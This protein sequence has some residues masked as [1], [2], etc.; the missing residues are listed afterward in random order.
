M[1]DLHAM[2]LAIRDGAAR[3]TIL[4]ARVVKQD[5]KIDTLQCLHE[6]LQ[7]EIIDWHPSFPL[8]DLPGNATLLLDQSIPAAMSPPASALPALID[9]SMT[10]MEPTPPTFKDAAS[11][12]GL[13][14]EP[15]QG[16]P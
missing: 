2:A 13:M 9:L 10:G 1:P 4:E 6:S 8:L 5:G 7:Y 11:I 3:I 16:Q 14:F 15:T 12:E